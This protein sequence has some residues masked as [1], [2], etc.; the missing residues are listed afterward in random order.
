MFIKINLTFKNK[1]NLQLDLNLFFL[2]A[3]QFLH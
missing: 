2:T 3:L 1:V